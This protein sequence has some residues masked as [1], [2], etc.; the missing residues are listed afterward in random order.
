M[1]HKHQLTLFLLF[2]CSLIHAQKTIY[3]K[4]IDEE[5]KEPLPYANVFVGD[6]NNSTLTDIDGSFQLSVSD[7]TTHFV[8][9]YIGY[10]KKTI[11]IG[12]SNFYEITL[13]PRIEQL[14]DVVLNNTSDL[15]NKIIRKAIYY[16]QKNDPDNKFKTYTYRSYNKLII[17]DQKRLLNV[18]LD[19][20]QTSVETIITEGRA[21][22]SEQISDFSYSKEYGQKE[23]IVAT[24]TAG[25]KKPVYELLAMKVQSNTWYKEEYVVFGNEYAGP[26]SQYP[27]N[28]YTYKVLDTTKTNRPAFVIYFQ[29]RRQKKVAALEGVLYIDTLN[30]GLQKAVGQLK[31]EVDINATQ[32]FTFYERENIWFPQRH[33]VTLKPGST[34]KKVSIFGGNISLGSLPEGEDDPNLF[35]RSTTINKDIFFNPV[36]TEEIDKSA[37]TLDPNALSQTEDFWEENRMIPFTERDQNS[38]EEIDSIITQE[39]INRKLD[40]RHNFNIGYYPIGFWNL[41]LRSIFKYNDYEGIRLGAGGITNEKFSEKFRVN[42]FLM[43]GFKD[44]AF[45]YNIGSGLALRRESNT[46]LNLGYTKDIQEVGSYFYVTDAREYTLFEPRLVNINFYYKH[47]TYK[48]SLQHNFFPKLTSEFQLASSKI[49]QTGPYRFVYNN[50][51]LDRYDI[52][53]ASA[54]FRWSPFSQFL[55]S[56]DKIIEVDVGYPK[57]SFQFSQAIPHVLDGDFSYTKLGARVM[58]NIHRITQNN[59]EIIAEVNY[60]RGEIPLTHAFHAYP[61]NPTKDELLQRFSIAGR[62]TFETMYFGEFFSDKLATIQAKHRLRPLHISRRVQPEIVFVT[63]HA[64][65]DMDD[66]ENHQGVG[67]QS[68]KHGYNEAALEINK[69]FFGFGLNFA[70]R[71]GAYYLPQFEDNLSLKFSFY[72]QL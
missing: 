28:N 59:T 2:F 43:Y 32:E 62:R 67:F 21:Y 60:V 12:E 38:F 41:D 31:G 51:V 47:R 6:G 42:G 61:N 36:L 35:L 22:L 55:K 20:T 40:V 45:K 1:H 25:F 23:N 17:D 34:G 24:R 37:I 66:I 26:L 46:W 72:F 49:E 5:L 56:P 54:S 39:R 71:Y 52:T 16:K 63:R 15:A 65:G 68:L 14:N 64:I 33:T 57:F 30:Y 29:P 18:R 58:Y 70:Y 44:N 11:S 48:A 27:F 8:V 4:V 53:E 50:E 19:T 69:I 10:Q 3:G 9:S 13:K 7:S